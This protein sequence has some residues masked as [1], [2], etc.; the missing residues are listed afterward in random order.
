MILRGCC[1][2]FGRVRFGGFGLGI[3]GRLRVEEVAADLF[4]QSRSAGCTST[5]HQ[6]RLVGSNLALTSGKQQC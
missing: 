5:L 1:N 2:N 6:P 3:F 4:E